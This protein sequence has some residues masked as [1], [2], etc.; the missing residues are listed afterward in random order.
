MLEIEAH[1][2]ALRPWRKGDE[3][4]LAKYANNRRVWINLTDRF[5]HPYTHDEAE[6]WIKRVEARGEP[7][8]NLAI[9]VEGGPVGGIGVSP[10]VDVYRRSAEIGYWLGEPF[11]G[12]GIA[13]EA[14]RLMT[15]YVFAN[16][17]F[18]RLQA[19][20]FEWNP[21]SCRVLEKAGYALEARLAKGV[22]KDGEVIDGLLYARL[23]E[24]PERAA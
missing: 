19:I 14:L 15:D 7:A 11:W 21:A 23:R 3:A 18:E 16:F 13:T 17:D 9:V 4:A 22:Y 8:R 1:G 20:V 6:A 10:N 24:P 2:F 5:P 12:R